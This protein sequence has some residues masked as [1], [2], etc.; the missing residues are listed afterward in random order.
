MGNL[1]FKLS[2]KKLVEIVLNS[3]YYCEKSTLSGDSMKI[4]DWS[5]IDYI[6]DKLLY[7]AII[8]RNLATIEDVKEIFDL[9]DETDFEFITSCIVTESI[10]NCIWEQL[11]KLPYDLPSSLSVVPILEFLATDKNVAEKNKNIADKIKHDKRPSFSKNDMLNFIR[12][13]KKEISVLLRELDVLKL[14]NNQSEWQVKANSLV[15]KVSNNDFRVLKW[16]EV[17]NLVRKN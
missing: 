3:Q 14:E 9:D 8:K 4:S 2:Q 1:N 7:P 17:Y 12:D 10:N 13:N 16:K 15:Q 11:Y 6:A 5:V